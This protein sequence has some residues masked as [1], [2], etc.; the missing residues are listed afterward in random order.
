MSYQIL[1]TNTYGIRWNQETGWSTGVGDSTGT[2]G[3]VGGGVTNL[4][5]P[6]TEG[7]GNPTAASGVAVSAGSPANALRVVKGLD[8]AQVHTNPN[9]HIK[10]PCGRMYFWGQKM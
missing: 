10:I 5:L 9:K 8:K 7:L 2:V 3:T 4:G 1:D 6:G